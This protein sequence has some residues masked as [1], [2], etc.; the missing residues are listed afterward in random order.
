MGEGVVMVVADTLEHARDACD[1]IDIEYENLPAVA[2]FGAHEL[3]C[4]PSL[5]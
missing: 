1:L 5:A 2:L 3:G 4:A